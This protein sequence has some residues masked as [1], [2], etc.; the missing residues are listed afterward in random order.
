MKQWYLL[1][2]LVLLGGCLLI[3]DDQE[4]GD[5][6]ENRRPLV[7]ITAGAATSDSAGIDYKVTF[8]WRGADEDGVVIRFEYAMDDTTT[9]SA[10]QDTT[11]FSTLLKFAATHENERTG[12]EL[13]S[14]WHTFYIRA[15]DNEYATSSIDRRY[16]NAR[17]IAPT[18]KINFP[19]VAAG[20]IP[21]FVKTFVVEWEG[22]DLDSSNPEKLPE[23]YEYKMIRIENAFIDDD[24][25]IDSLRTRDNRF[26]DTLQAGDRTRWIRVPS[27]VRER[28]LRDLPDTQGEVFIFAVRAVDEAGATEPELTNGINWIKFNVQDK[29]AKPIVTISERTLGGHTFPSDGEV[30]GERKPLEVPTNTPIRFEWIGD[31]SSYGSKP[32]NVNYGLD[33]PDPED[34]RYRDPRGIGGWIG[35]GKWSELTTPLTFPDTEDGQTHVF[36]LRMRDVSDLRSSERLCTIVLRV[37]A[38]RFARTALL[39]DDARIS[40]GF[41]GTVQDGIH[42]AFIDRFIGRIFHFATDGL[43]R[44]S[45]YRLRKTGSTTLPEGLNPTDNETLPLSLMAQFSSIL[46]NFNFSGG[47]TTGLWYHEHESPPGATRRERRLLSSYVGA[48]GK[49]FLFGGRPLSAIVSLTGGNAGGDYPKQPPQVGQS[50]RAFSEESF[51]WRFLHV[52]N[53]VVGIDQL[54]CNSQPPQDHQ[55]W[56]DGL[57]AC[58]SANPLYP[59]LYLDPAK[60]D[61]ER[62]SDCSNP[63]PPVGGILDYEGV[64]EGPSTEP[65]YARHNPDAGLDTLYVGVPYNWHGTPPSKWNGMVVAQRYESTAADTLRG[66]TQG[67]IMM[68]LFQPYLFQEGPVV[69][70]GTAAVNW[71]MTGG[72]N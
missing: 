31:A 29:E 15:I 70:A 62:L 2:M 55:T 35:W 28:V 63:K 40:Y 33:V 51:L 3:P 13:F 60:W 19:K 66:T 67:R 11:G 48:G 37:V 72:D 8:Q 12:A 59:D 50:N 39:V 26:L 45:M 25:A 21:V 27:S 10:W 14:D 16:F 42:D 58:M 68:F 32:G 38:F 61:T 4:K 64:L 6:V 43:E 65:G 22:E 71:L 34:D 57:V 53:Q 5:R 52:R 30:W 24:A 1:P 18:S 54:K 20:N 56:R 36:Y 49:L 41:S 47:E 7:Q 46:W 17:T 44:R 69:N 9:Q 23:F